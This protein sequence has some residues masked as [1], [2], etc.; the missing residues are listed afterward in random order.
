M[1]LSQC[2]WK[3]GKSVLC[4]GGMLLSVALTGCGSAVKPAPVAD[5]SLMWPPPPAQPRIGYEKSIYKPSDLGF[6]RSWWKAT[7]GYVVGNNRGDLAFVKPTGICLDEA[8]NLCVTDTGTKA[9]WF[10]DNARK[11]YKRWSQIDNIA[12]SSPVAVAKKNGI[13]YVADSGLGAIVAFNEK[14]KLLFVITEGLER[15]S[16]LALAGQTLCVTDAAR[17]RVEVFDLEGQHRHGFGRRGAGNGEFN[18][19]SHLTL[20]QDAVPAL[21]VTDAMNFRIQKVAIEGEPLQSIGSIGTGTGSF[22]R[23][24]GV[25]T[26]RDGNLYVVDAL[27]DNIQIFDNEKRF[28]MHWGE[29]GTEPGSF[30]LPTGIAIDAQERIWVADSYNRRIQ[31]FKRIRGYEE[32]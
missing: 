8:G 28:L 1:S 31:V 19:P 18:Y 6:K 13:I 29:S 2:Q 24:K 22:S 14:G 26:D 21:F 12:F 17:H 25:A 32:I 11:R 7:L 9:V 15:P 16:G 23:P 3:I 20:T 27:F 10:F 5:R 4:L 30:W